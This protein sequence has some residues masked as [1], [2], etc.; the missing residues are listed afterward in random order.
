MARSPLPDLTR[1]NGFDYL[2]DELVLS[3]SAPMIS[4]RRLLTDRYTIPSGQLLYRHKGAFYCWSGKHY[5]EITDEYLTSDI[6]H[7]LEYA[8]R[9]VKEKDDS[10]K[11]VPFHPKQTHVNEIR[12]AMKAAAYLGDL[13]NAPIWLAEAA[14]VAATEIIACDNG[15]LHLPTRDLLPH[16]PS[17]YTHNAIDYAYDARAPIPGHWLRFLDSL[18]PDDPGSIGTLQEVFGYSLVADTSQQKAFLLVGPPRCGKG[19]IARTL[20]SVIGQENAAAPTLT[21]LG[22]T[23][24]MQP[25][26]GKRLAVISDARLSGRAD[27]AVIA[28]RLLSVTGE[29]AITLDRKNREHWTGKLDVRFLILTNELPRIADASGALANR[30]IV[31][32]L[33]NSFLGKEDLA[34]GVRIAPERPGILNWA[35]EGYERLSD[36]GYFLQPESSREAI[37]E[38]LDLGS[39]ISAFIRERCIVTPGRSIACDDLF[40]AWKS[41][42]GSQGR[43]AIGTKPDFGKHLRAA[44]PHLKI[45]QHRDQIGSRARFYEGISIA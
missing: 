28:E 11:S 41:W 32:N 22:T 1:V 33:T 39:P 5:I 30:F 31:L 24:G 25:L 42:C 37:Q 10:W 15:L 7:F 26:I 8:R 27:P 19:T 2:P 3:P 21:G 40:E 16:T 13:L 35:I 29:D 4:A 6:Y 45:V 9:Q 17:F 36:R 34:L 23:F 20:I 14:D 38:L 44:Q 43:D 18:W 12:S